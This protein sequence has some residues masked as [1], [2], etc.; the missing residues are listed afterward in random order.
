M[1]WDFWSLSPES[2]HQVTILFSDRGTLDG[3]RHMNGYGSHTFSLINAKNELVN[4]STT[5]RRSRDQELRSRRG[6]PHEVC[7]HVTNIVTKWRLLWEPPFLFV[8][9]YLC[10]GCGD[11]EV[12]G[13]GGAA[14]GLGSGFLPGFH[15]GFQLEFAS[16]RM[17]S[18]M[19]AMALVMWVKSMAPISSLGWW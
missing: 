2:L 9:F 12:D 14:V 8:D 3:Y 13:W 6:R 10:S 19:E 1:I 18:I 5:S 7:E 4:V 15:S 17:G 16:H 11:G